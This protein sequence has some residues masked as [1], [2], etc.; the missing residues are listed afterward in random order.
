MS[1]IGI[2]K[3]NEM[4]DEKIEKNT[5]TN[6]SATNDIEDIEE[7]LGTLMNYDLTFKV[8]VLGNSGVGKSSLLLKGIKN[9]IYGLINP[10]IVT[11]IKA[12]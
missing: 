11:L 5:I 4:R 10:T 2:N 9:E 12:H 3:K 7:P 1:I 8:I 6:L